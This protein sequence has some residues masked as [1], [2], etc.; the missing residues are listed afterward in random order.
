[1]ATETQKKCKTF[2]LNL[3]FYDKETKD[4]MHS[5]LTK[6]FEKGFLKPW[7]VT[8]EKGAVVNHIALV[9]MEGL[10]L[11]GRAGTWSSRRDGA[12]TKAVCPVCV[13]RYAKPL[14]SHLKARLQDATLRTEVLSGGE[15]RIAVFEEVRKATNIRNNFAFVESVAGM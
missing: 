10:A 13:A 6:T 2:F 3:F 1:M 9:A 12:F 8:A 4:E 5:I 14:R 15:E 7:F 11:C